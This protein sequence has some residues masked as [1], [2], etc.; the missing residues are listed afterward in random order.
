MWPSGSAAVAPNI[1]RRA[2]PRGIRNGD[3]RRDTCLDAN[4]C[5][6]ANRCFNADSCLDTCVTYSCGDGWTHAVF[7]ECDDGNPDTSDDCVMCANATCGDVA[8]AALISTTTNIQPSATM[9]I[10]MRGK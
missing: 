5:F 10:S 6:S 1:A 7:E 8:S 2:T 4:N 3:T 9:C